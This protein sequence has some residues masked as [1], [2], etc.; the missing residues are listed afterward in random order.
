MAEPVVA[1]AEAG[2]GAGVGA[3]AGTASGSAGRTVTEETVTVEFGGDRDGRAPLTWGQRAIWH[4]IRRTAPNDHYFNIGRVLPL[5]DRG[6]PATVAEAVQ[7]LG[8]LMGRHEALRT[9]LELTADGQDADAGGRTDA[10]QRLAA[11]GRL[12]VTLAHAQDPADAERTA[13]ALLDRLSATRFAYT[14]EWPVRAALVAVGD[15]VTHAVLVLCHLAADGHGAEVLVR[16]L[17]LLVRRGSAGRPPAATP[18]D[19]AREQHGDAGR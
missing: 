9:R 6:R 3:D 2:A 12:P 17:R 13:H 4:A 8:G 11:T 16:D 1:A 15:R 19:L 14:S 18:L 10:G 7:A 5:A